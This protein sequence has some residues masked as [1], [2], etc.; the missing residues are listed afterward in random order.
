MPK[1]GKAGSPTGRIA[2]LHALAHIELNA[3]DLACDG[4]ALIS[5][6]VFE[7][8]P[9]YFADQVDYTIQPTMIQLPT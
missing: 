8:E 6:E 3:V 4:D 2:L 1:R 5:R 7:A 9:G